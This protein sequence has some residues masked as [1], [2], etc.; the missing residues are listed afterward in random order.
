MWPRDHRVKSVKCGEYDYLITKCD[1]SISQSFLTYF[2]L[3]SAPKYFYY[4]LFHQVWQTVITKCVRYYKVWQTVI[5]KCVRYYKVWQTVITKCVRYFKVWRLYYKVRQVLQCA[6][7]IT[8]WDVTEINTTFSTGADLI[9]GVLQGSVMGP[10]LFNIYLN[11]FFF[12]LQDINIWN[13]VWDE[14]LESVLDK[15]EGNS[16]LAIFVWKQLYE[17]KCW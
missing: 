10:L 8:K 1:N 14:S 5:T 11:D 16:E 3:Q 4:I 15:L 13:F 9:S 17:T 12:Y 2:I 6:T 7:V